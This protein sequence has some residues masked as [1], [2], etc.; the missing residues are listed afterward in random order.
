MMRSLVAILIGLMIA[1]GSVPVRG[2]SLDIGGLIQAFT[3]A[4]TSFFDPTGGFM[5]YVKQL[6]GSTMAQLGHGINEGLKTQLSGI[7]DLSDYQNQVNVKLA[8]QKEA[9]EVVSRTAQLPNGCISATMASH[10]APAQAA[11]SGYEVIESHRMAAASLSSNTVN[12]DLASIFDNHYRS[13][14]GAQD[15]Q[16]RRA[17]A[18]SN[19]APNGDISF[20]TLIHGAQQAVN[21]FIPGGSTYANLTFNDN[22]IHAA[23][24][25]IDN[26]FNPINTPN[27]TNG[28][29]NTGVG[30]AYHAYQLAEAARLSLSTTAAGEILAAST[31]VVGLG[32]AASSQW[33]KIAPDYARKLGNRQDIS[34]RELMMLETTRR[35][36][37]PDWY[38]LMASLDHPMQV[39]KEIAL[40]QAAQLYMQAQLYRQNETMIGLLAG[41]NTSTTKTYFKP[42]LDEQRASLAVNR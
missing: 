39:Q 11:K 26:A 37:S 20:S 32:T 10:I 38:V 42:L 22:Q 9:L 6:T 31:P 35:Y 34:W 1:M 13:F 17:K 4:L 19:F 21:A 33:Q 29:L 27:L 25:Y 30:R 41:I 18:E 8:Q 15:V 5:T 16:L 14:A 2:A 24:R 40:M 28:E 23:R 36:S 3:Q 7:A 12:S